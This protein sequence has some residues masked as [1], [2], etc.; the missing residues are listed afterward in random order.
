HLGS[1]RSFYGLHPDIHVV[2]LGQYVGRWTAVCG[3]AL[4]KLWAMRRLVRHTH[5]DVV[6]SFLTNVNVNV[7]MATRGLDVP[8]I[9]AE[10]TN[11]AHSQAAGRVLRAMRRWLY[12]RAQAVLVQTQASIDDMH[13]A[14]PGLKH[15]WA[16]PNPLPPALPVPSDSVQ[17][18][19]SAQGR[20]RRLRIV[21]MGRLVASKQFDQLIH[22]FS[23]IAS[24]HPGWELVIWGD[25]PRRSA[26]QQQIDSLGLANRVQLPGVTRQPWH[27]LAQAQLFAMTSRVEGFP[28]VLLE[29]MA[30]GCP[31]VVVDCPSGPAEMTQQGE[32]ARLVP[33]DDLPALSAALQALMSDS[34]LR[35]RLGEKG[36]QDVAVRY[37]LEAILEQWDAVFRAVSRSP[38]SA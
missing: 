16:I 14:V 36:A 1:D 27:E 21:A 19:V 23:G 26:L 30:L 35:R 33:L 18:S 15:V 20:G 37:D 9:V 4:A 3:P 38:S 5:P 31:A 28:N 6:L 8:V 13:V 25:G 2:W 32:L 10:R 12:P 7:L 11:P 29:A 22:A 24:Q 34:A 17:A